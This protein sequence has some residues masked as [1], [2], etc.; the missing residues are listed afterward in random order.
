MKSVPIPASDSNEDERPIK[1]SPNTKEIP[2][3]T[4]KRPAIASRKFQSPKLT[5]P[6]R[7]PIMKK[8]RLVVNTATPIL[9]PL[10]KKV[11]DS[12]SSSKSS[13]S[14]ST[15]ASVAGTSATPETSKIKHRTV[16]AAAQFKSPLS[17]GASSTTVPSVKLTPTIQALERKLQA[18]KR[19]VKVKHDGEEEILEGLV[20]KWTDAGREIAWEVWGLVK[21][22]GG[23][24]SSAGTGKKG[25]KSGGW[26]GDQ[27]GEKREGS[28]GKRGFE[29]AWG[30]DEK[31]DTKKRK[32]D[33]GERNWGWDVS[34]QKGEGGNDGHDDQA[35]REVYEHH[36]GT[37]EVEEEEEE[38]EPRQDTLGTMLKQL[39]IAPATLGWNEDE[40]E[41][42]DEIS[43]G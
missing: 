42:I 28:A 2:V 20:K 17:S 24:E 12:P 15:Q 11:L 9:S 8:P 10:S 35:M 13:A 18:L 22:M 5:A 32:I 30:W 25:I 26:G 1:K 33:E 16:R 41:F 34:S 21:D 39:G 19:A 31:G 43:E 29:D 37:A 3:P 40:G 38:D 7:S 4:S 36:D 27:W 14:E 23:G 6:F